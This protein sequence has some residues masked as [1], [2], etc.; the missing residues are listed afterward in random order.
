MTT[1]LSLLTALLA[2]VDW[3]A[4]AVQDRRT[5]AWAKPATLA[6]LIATAVALGATDSA[7]GWW[8]LA[9]LLLGLAGDVLLL[10]DSGPRFL[11][12]LA[13]FLGGHLAYVV[14]FVLLGLAW[15][16]WAWLAA[17]TLLVGLIAIR[18]VVGA[19]RRDGGTAMAA[20]VALYIVVIATMLVVGFGTG[21]PLVALGATS[22]LASDSLLAIL[23]FVR[24]IP[25]GDLLVMVSYH[26]AQALIVLGVLGWR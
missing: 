23:R 7:A 11:L 19:A 26:L 10:A 12:G 6:A 24:R 13:S 17:P 15:P 4:V 2:L 16:A 3:R 20:A 18:R 8:L 21:R 25:R 1:A 14:C 22:F 5:E 9:G